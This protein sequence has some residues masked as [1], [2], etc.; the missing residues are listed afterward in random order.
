[1]GVRVRKAVRADLETVSELLSRSTLNSRGL[2]ARVRARMFSP[3]WGGA[4]PYFGYL[5]ETE[6]GEVVGF[7]GLLFTSRTL[8]GSERKFCE[9]HSWYVKE[10]YRKESI[11]LLLP[12]LGMK[13]AT[14]L[15]YTPTRGV[16]DISI[17]FGFSE[18]ESAVLAVF[19]RPSWKAFSGQFVVSRVSQHLT[20]M[21]EGE[22]R[23][24]YQ[25]HAHLGCD[26]YI[27]LD[28]R[29]GRRCYF[30]LKKMR[31]RWYEPFGRVLYISRPE[32]FH[33]AL[34]RLR[35]ELCLRRGLQCLVLNAG[36]F[37]NLPIPRARLIRREVPSLIKG[38]NIEPATVKPIYTLPL[39]LEYRLH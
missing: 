3:V 32:L 37:E 8:N 10:Q 38:K 35:L 24:I 13:G 12:V 22:D 25:D 21:L 26:H 33:R 29:S 31:R 28:R 39:L 15:N 2:P 5:M 14:L 11:N 1:M 4:E 27:I 20:D 30:M 16:Y 17:Q 34:P 6:A 19:P 36:D 23:R 9:L 18:L 7:L